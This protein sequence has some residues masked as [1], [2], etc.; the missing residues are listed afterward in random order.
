MNN[1]PET[2]K[3]GPTFDPNRIET[4]IL[5][6]WDKEKTFEKSLDKGN[7]AKQYSFYDGPPYA[8]GSPH[9]GHILTTT[10]KDTVTRYWTMCGFRVDRRVGWDCHG[11]PVENLVEKE[12]GIKDKK[13][14]EKLGIEKFNEACR[15]SV[16]RYVEDFQQVLK[17]VGRWADYSNAYA[18]LNP[19]FMES[20]WW[21]FKKVWDA[22]LVYKGFRS[23]PYCPRCAT[24]LSNFETAQGYKTVE[25][26]AI[27]VK[28]RLKD[29]ADVFI[30]VWTTTPWT[31]PGNVAAAINPSLIYA[32]V[33]YKGEKLILAKDRIADNLGEVE[34]AEEFSGEKLVG[35][36]Y[37]PLY[38]FV[39][40]DK[41]AFRIIAAD[42]VSATD[43]TGIVH[44]APAFG[45]DDLRA[46]QKEGLPLLQPV[47]EFG[48]FIDAVTPWTGMF[49]KDADRLIIK[50]LKERSL[51]IREEKY[52][53]EYPFCWRCDTPLI[54]YA[55]DSWFIAVS[56]VREKL[57]A[58]NEQIRW[59]PGHLKEGRFGQGLKDAPDWAISRNRYWSTPIPVWSCTKCGE[60]TAIGSIEEL[61]KFGA[62]LKPLYPRGDEIDLHR[63]Y[64]DNVSF[65][66]P[67]CGNQTERI[68]EVFDVWMDS[69][70]MPYG[71]WH[72][73]FENKELVEKTFPADFIAEGL[74]QTRGWFYTLHVL[75]GILTLNKENNLG[76]NK[77]AFKNVVVNGIV[78]AEDGK[79]LSKRLKNYPNVNEVFE[80]Y[81]ADSL[82]MYMLS[83]A[84]LGE[85]YF[86]SEK[87]I[88]GFYRKYTLPLFNVVS[89]LKTYAEHAGWQFGQS[90]EVPASH[91]LDKWILA[92]T[93]EL[94]LD[95]SSSM[96]E[97]RLDQAARKLVEFIDDL[98]NWYVRGS[99]KRF[100]SK[101]KMVYVPAF[102]TLEKVLRE[103]SLLTAPMTPFFSEHI[104]RQ[105]AGTSPHLESFPV[106]VEP[107]ASL[108]NNM[109]AIRSVISVALQLRAKAGIKVR[110]PLNKVVLSGKTGLWNDDWLALVKDEVNV[111]EVL[112]TKDFPVGDNWVSGEALE[113]K[114]GLNVEIDENL[115]H[116]GTARDL[117][118]FTQDLRKKTGLTVSDTIDL[119]FATTDDETAKAVVLFKEL[120][121]KETRAKVVS[122]DLET[123]QASSEIKLNGKAVTIKLN[124]ASS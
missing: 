49:V 38:H 75:A 62:D 85:N 58:N 64:I 86:I 13:E 103:F 35:K 123:A 5:Q 26:P 121:A 42:F 9:Y 100:G 23:S 63:P 24:P 105:L 124:R 91:L 114:V 3:R 7:D 54:Y 74:D 59:V 81:G 17:R 69:G 71:Q 95:V 15:S 108:L 101:D 20:V 56:K 2:E 88:Q 90:R 67:K 82:R 115:K 60:Y 112:E 21:T 83:S 14:I 111:K 116:E 52:S 12:L 118:R 119:A 73:P 106:G 61:K 44:M 77:P 113:I 94:K 92:R 72:Y 8:T 109:R 40:P 43:G 57:I 99:R 102:A 4:D 16:F 34:I 28:L 27:T 65:P 11:L 22:G 79:K 51:L 10:I 107:E 96:N 33:V 18:T 68:K 76:E 30:L 120:I 39:K 80:K 84:T 117:I 48:K 36:E 104:Y 1:E 110:Q 87:I 37:D 53:H 70:S 41:P 89:F 97:Y 25:D 46:A 122:G 55:M 19:S 47:N 93:E 31:L 45:E 6:I 66:C 98:S 78:L 29:E 50:E 32:K